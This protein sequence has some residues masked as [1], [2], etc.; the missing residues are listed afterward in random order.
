MSHR[1]EIV[2]GLVTSALGVIGIA[3]AIFGPATFS[4]GT[5][6]MTAASSSL[7]DHGLDTPTVFYLGVMLLASLAVSAGAYLRSNGALTEGATILWFSAAALL[8]G[9]VIT[10]PGSTTA[11]VPTA[12]HTNTADSVGI[13][14][15]FTP[16]VLMAF[17][18]AAVSMTV[19]HTPGTPIA[20]RPH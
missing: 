6:W 10:L 19:H 17:V 15:Y 18:T 5:D 20:L 2:M 4:Y 8:V 12:L 1:I 9:A 13:G 7:W 3:F 16:A 14:I 11:F